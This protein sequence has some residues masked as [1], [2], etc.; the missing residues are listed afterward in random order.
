MW[1]RVAFLCC[2]TFQHISSDVYFLD[3]QLQK[4][5]ENTLSFACEAKD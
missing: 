4:K 1:I 3:V 2:F 5:A